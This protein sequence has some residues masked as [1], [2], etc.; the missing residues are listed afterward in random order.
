MTRNCT[1]LV[2]LDTNNYSKLTTIKY[3]ISCKNNNWYE[4]G[5]FS[6]FYVT[7]PISFLASYH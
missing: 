3:Q 1:N 4:A 5:G 7:S 6:S 2:V